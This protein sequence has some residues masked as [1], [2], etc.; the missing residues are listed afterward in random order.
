MTAG[1][2]EGVPRFRDAGVGGG[3]AVGLLARGRK[4][5]LRLGVVLDGFAFALGAEEAAGRLTGGGPEGAF[6]AG[7]VPAPPGGMNLWEGRQ[8][9]VCAHGGWGCREG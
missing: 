4:G 5:T 8:P 3:L 1:A 7:A 6:A 9:R 2:A